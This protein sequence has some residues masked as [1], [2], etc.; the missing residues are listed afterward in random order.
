MFRDA[1]FRGSRAILLDP[2]DAAP[3]LGSGPDVPAGQWAGHDPVLRDD[4]RTIIP[5]GG[6]SP[7]QT[8]PV[9]W[10][11]G[12]VDLMAHRFR[13]APEPFACAD[14]EILSWEFD[15]TE[16]STVHLQPC[17]ASTVHDRVQSAG[18]GRNAGSARSTI[19]GARP[20]GNGEP[21]LPDTG[22]A[23]DP[24][25][26]SERSARCTGTSVSSQDLSGAITPPRRLDRL[27]VADW[28]RRS[29]E[30]AA[31]PGLAA[32]LAARPPAPEL[33]DLVPAAGGSEQQVWADTLLDSIVARQRLINHLQARQAADFAD[34]ERNYPGLVEFL[35]TEVGF[36]LNVTEN[37]ATRHLD[38]ARRVRLRLP[39]T[40]DAWD[41]GKLSTDKASYL[42]E[43][44]RDLDQYHT[45]R[46]E[47]AVL[48][49]APE[50][51][52]PEFRAAV[53]RAIITTD[54]EGAQARHQHA[55][56]RRRVQKIDCE[57]GMAELRYYSTAS[58]VQ[59]VWET[60]TGIAQAAKT[61]D[62]G[63]NLD[64]RRAD[65][66]IDLAVGVLDQA[67]WRG[68]P[69]PK[70]RGKRTTINVTMPITAMAGGNEVCELSGYGPITS[71]Q[72]WTLLGDAELRRMVCEP[73]SGE[74]LEASVSDYQPPGWLAEHII[75]R[76]RT[77]VAPGCRMPAD[78]S[79]ID[80][81]IPYQQ[82]GQTSTENLNVLCQHHHRGK[83]GG[84][85]RL[86]RLA[87]G[88]YHWTTPLG[89]TK[90]RPATRWWTPPDPLA[91]WQARREAVDN[92]NIV[93]PPPDHD[94]PPF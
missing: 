2:V 71:G 62:D 12:N 27:A 53:R 69:L 86:V 19:A 84:G 10:V 21:C 35:P 29:A 13:D 73:H 42:A 82:G 11:V 3:W 88:S 36:A 67:M 40:W 89:R 60:L 25:T 81:R 34:L 58:D 90:T 48:P 28:R 83:D 50:Q 32:H 75:A 79:Q 17:S 39:A 65:A 51:T 64:Q 24:R 70:R 85:M 44:T 31:G 22:R 15:A 91:A 41:T 26:A 16:L 56:G 33:L 4:E 55:A 18:S 59:L 7:G 46:V 37:W 20:P 38:S 74:L 66:L 43:A 61:P 6:G 76:D 54:P 47:K 80:H 1:H 78:R 14:G 30:L 49:K 5:V 77:C 8:P 72:A 23:A 9:L 93:D 52:L 63:R 94:P 68:R 87:D 92:W 57:D 45:R